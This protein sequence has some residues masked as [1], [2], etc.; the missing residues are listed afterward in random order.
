[1]Y[2][3]RYQILSSWLETEPLTAAECEERRKDLEL[4]GATNIRM[5]PVRMK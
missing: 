5:F 4:I 3:L 1:M 2:Y